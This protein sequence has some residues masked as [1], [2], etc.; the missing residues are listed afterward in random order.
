M[1]ELRLDGKLKHLGR[2]EQEL[3]AAQVYDAAVYAL[4]VRVWRSLSWR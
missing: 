1:A 4:K 2:F 3:Q